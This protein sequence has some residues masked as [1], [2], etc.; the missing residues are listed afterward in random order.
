MICESRLTYEVEIWGVDEGWKETDR[1]QKDFVRKCSRYP[2]VQQ[3]G[4]EL[5]LG[6]D[7]RR[8]KICGM[9]VKYQLRILQMYNG[10]LK[11]KTVSNGS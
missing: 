8:G 4:S 11:K 1:N 2:D 9:A 3:M 7:S 10:K 6:R 5:E